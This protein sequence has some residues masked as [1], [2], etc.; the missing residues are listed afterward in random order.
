MHRSPRGPGTL[1][2]A[3]ARD[4]CAKACR[5]AQPGVQG[6][7]QPHRDCGQAGQIEQFAGQLAE[8]PPPAIAAG[9]EP[10]GLGELT[11]IQL[12]RRSDGIRFVRQG[13]HSPVGQHGLADRLQV[14]AEDLLGQPSQHRQIGLDVQR[15]VM[16]RKR[17]AGIERAAGE[18]DSIS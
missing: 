14:D 7:R 18:S 15:A 5:P 9:F 17:I 2:S 6:L 11:R 1:R 4:A 10:F 3:A 8:E 16:M 12:L 13:I